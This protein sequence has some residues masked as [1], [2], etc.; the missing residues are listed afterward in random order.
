MNKKQITQWVNNETTLRLWDDKVTGLFIK[1]NAKSYSWNVSY[2]NDSGK[3]HSI[4]IGLYPSVTL[5]AARESARQHL[6][7]LAQ[8]KDPLSQR[9]EKKLASK[10]TIQAYFDST[11]SVVLNGKKSGN[12]TAA[13]FKRHCSELMKLTFAEINAKH[14][15]KWHMNMIAKDLKDSTIQRVY[16]AFKTLVN[17]AVKKQHITDS[18]IHNINLDKYHRPEQGVKQV[19]ERKYLSKEQIANLMRALDLYQEKRRTERKNSRLHG[20]ANLPSFDDLEYVDFVKPAILVMFYTGFR[21]SDIRTLTW[22]EINLSSTTP[23]IRKALE[24][25]KHKNNEPQTFPLMPEATQ[26]L[27]KWKEQS[28]N[29]P[30]GLVFPSDKGTIRTKRFISDPWKKHIRPLASLPED[31]DLYNLRHNFASWLVMSGTD[32][33]TVAKLMGHADTKMVEKHYG[34]LAPEHKQNA[35]SKAFNMMMP[36]DD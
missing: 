19:N 35:L 13:Y 31:F 25:S 18:P 3:K 21:P 9:K 23:T 26:T 30:L 34:H 32:L 14:I 6:I 11:Y 2:R 22:E 8:G 20:K 24:K 12:E 5:D 7:N 36:N 1:R 27:K 4:K 29:S 17:D 16:G 15:H 33:L 28:N 10:D